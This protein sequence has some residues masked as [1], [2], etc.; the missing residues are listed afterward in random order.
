MV[1]TPFKN[2]RIQRM[3]SMFILI[4]GVLLMITENIRTIEVAGITV[5][6]FVV[7]MLVAFVG[8]LYF[9]DA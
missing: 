3:T 1:L 6:M 2:E 9:M 8:F 7:G 4:L 5:N